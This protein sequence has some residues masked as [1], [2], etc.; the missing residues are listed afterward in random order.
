MSTH[1]TYI[2]CGGHA[3]EN[4]GPHHGHL[5]WH[6]TKVDT[7]QEHEQAVVES[8]S[9]RL[10]LQPHEQTNASNRNPSRILCA[11]E[12]LYDP[13]G[14]AALCTATKQRACFGRIAHLVSKMSAVPELKLSQELLVSGDSADWE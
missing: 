4:G 3:D 10:L 7:A 14:R 6:S 13:A 9:N 5:R 8:A 12:H 11:N 2:V 1:K